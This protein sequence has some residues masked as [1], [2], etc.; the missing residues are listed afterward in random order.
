MNIGVDCRT[1]LNPQNGEKAGVGHYTYYLVKNLL[2]IDKKN[3]YYLF[4]DHR[5]IN[6]KEFQQKNVKIIRFPLSQY[7]KYLPFGYSHY[8]VAKYIAN[9]HLDVF[10]APA[11][12]LPLNFKGKSVVTIHDLAIYKH[13]EW[14]PPKQKFSTKIS[15]PQSVN[16]ANKII[17]ISEST[18]KDLIN[19]LNVASEEIKVV[20]EGFTQDPKLNKKYI[21]QV[22][23]K[24]KIKNNFILHL[25]T[26]EPRKN[27]A[28]LIKAFDDLVCEKFKKYK[29][30]ELILAGV[31]GWKYKPIFQAISAAKCGRVRYIG[32]ISQKE[33]MA[34]LTSA[35]CFAFP[36][37]WEGFGL[38]AL[39]AI[40]LKTPVLTSNISSLPEVVGKAGVLVDPYKISSIKNGLHKILSDKRVIKRFTAQCKKQAKKFSWQKCAK[41]TLVVYKQIANS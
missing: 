20:Y 34:L 16:K 21:E 2:K 39:E 4:F 23:N 25:G 7:K 8:F 13:P 1:M 12:I 6:L 30:Y 41:E 32:Y 37:L 18:K 14:F 11:N 31:K 3:I 40:S 10:H 35:T 22:K 15:V 26:L 33:K 9:Y 28:L 19:I 36:S 27:A 5:F 38:P 17:A 29:D 24:Y